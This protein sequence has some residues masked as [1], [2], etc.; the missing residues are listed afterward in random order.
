MVVPRIG[1]AELERLRAHLL[2]CCPDLVSDL[3]G[4]LEVEAT[5]RHF[6][7]EPTPDDGA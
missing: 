6:H 5:L 4:P 1:T 3:T 7:V 2:G